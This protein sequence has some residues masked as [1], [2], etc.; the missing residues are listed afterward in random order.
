[1]WKG[2]TEGG[3]AGFYII[4]P[5]GREKNT[6]WAHQFY[7]DFISPPNS[8]APKTMESCFPHAPPQ[9]N[10]LAFLSSVMPACF[11]LV[12]AFEILIGGCLRP[13]LII[14]I[15]FYC[16]SVCCPER[17]YGVRPT[18]SAQV[19]RPPQYPSYRKCWLLVDCCV[20]QSKDGHLRPRPSPSLCFSMGCILAPQTKDKRV[21]RAHLMHCAIDG[22]I[23]SSGT[24]IWGYGWS[25][26]GQRGPKPLEGRVAAAHVGCCV[27]WLRIVLWLVVEH[28]IL[29]IL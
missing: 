22:S 5:T 9:S 3:V 7:Y 21:A 8:I 20:V 1:M 25:S 11:W 23:G 10:L 6:W 17:W 14:F 28:C 15:L 19:V 12:V 27:L 26:H 16:C 13:R 4:V 18:C 2:L 29:P 24:K